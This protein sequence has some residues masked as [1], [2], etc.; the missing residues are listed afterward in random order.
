MET[1]A[2]VVALISVATTVFKLVFIISVSDLTFFPR[3]YGR[4]GIWL[5]LF[6][7]STVWRM[8]Y[9]VSSSSDP[10]IALDFKDATKQESNIIA[11]AVSTS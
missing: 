11:V 4:G 6:G 8:Q 10:R 7:T 1:V 5:L 9:K 3:H 2:S